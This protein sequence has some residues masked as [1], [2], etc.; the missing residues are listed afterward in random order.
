MVPDFSVNIVRKFLKLFYT[1]SVNLSDPWELEDIKEFGCK[2]LGLSMGLDQLKFTRYSPE[3]TLAYTSF[4]SPRCSIV[5]SSSNDKPDTPSPIMPILEIMPALETMP[6]S[7]FAA[8]RHKPKPRKFLKPKGADN[9]AQ[10]DI[11]PPKPVKPKRAD[12]Q[13][14]PEIAAPQPDN[15]FLECS[16]EQVRLKLILTYF[17]LGA[18]HKLYDAKLSKMGLREL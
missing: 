5:S 8:K 4:S 12:T 7:N 9:Q 13:A 2:E 1:G 10:P 3:E 6:L 18:V 17:E 16:D 11:G 15:V 14:Q